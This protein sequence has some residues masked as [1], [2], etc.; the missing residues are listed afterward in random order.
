VAP[1]AFL[2]QNIQSKIES[3]NMQSLKQR[4]GA[5]QDHA[6]MP[7]S[8]HFGDIMNRIN[9]K[10]E[11]NIFKSL[12]NFEIKAPIS[13]SKLMEIIK[14]LSRNVST[15]PATKVISISN[16]RKFAAAA[17]ILLFALGGYFVVQKFTAS[18]SENDNAS[19][20]NTNNTIDP[21][22]NNNVIVPKIDSIPSVVSNT[23]NGLQVNKRKNYLETSRKT[24]RSY[25]KNIA[26]ASASVVALPMTEMTINGAV[27]PIIDND[28]LVT[29]TSFSPD[30]LPA[31]LQVEKPVATTITLDQYTSIN[32]SEGMGAMMKKMYKTKK[33]GK[34]TRKARKQK[35]KLE[36]WKKAD[37]E[38]FNQNA[39]LNPLDP[40][41]LGNFILNK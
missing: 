22:K 33:S 21:N 26:D 40:R 6:V 41:D 38:Y 28:Y 3:D 35:E 30:N 36:K 24:A 20:A 34:P 7:A 10:D 4:F 13:F 31:F 23:S 5:L 12:K 9:E 15:A 18:K 17:A 29:F 2:F 8:I 1:P 14:G 27:F 37:T 19:L 11:L 39:N 32:I 25:G 16:V